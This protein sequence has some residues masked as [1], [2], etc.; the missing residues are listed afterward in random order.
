[1]APLTKVLFL[2]MDAADRDLVQQWAAEG[3]MPNVQ[4]L[5][6]RGVVG[7]TLAPAGFFVGS[8]WP[9][10]TTG[11]SP[12]RHSVHSWEQIRNGT[13]EV[14]RCEAPVELKREPFWKVLSRAGKRL[15]ILDMPLSGVAENLNGIQIEEWGH[16]DAVHGF[17]TWPPSL[18]D[19]V[20]EKFGPPPGFSCDA[21]RTPEQLAAF[22]DRLVQAVRKKADLTCHYLQQGGW[23]FFSQVFTESHCVGHQCWH[24]Q[25]TTSPWYQPAIGAVAGNPLK[26]V[27]I[28]IDRAMG[29]ILSLVGDDTIVIFVIGHGM[30]HSY[31][32]YYLFPQILL[33]L[34]VAKPRTKQEDARATKAATDTTLSAVW[35]ALPQGMKDMLRPLRNNLRDWIDHDPNW[36]RPGGPRHI[37]L[38]A[39]QCFT[40]DN[41]H[42]ASAIRLNLAG[43]EPSGVL[44][45]G[46]EVEAF[47]AQL[48]RDLLEIRDIDRDIPAFIK[49][50]KTS[51]LFQGE[52]LDAL[53]DL[54]A[55]WNPA[56]PVGKVRLSS[57]K[58]G[59]LEGE[60]RLS[61]TGEHKREGLFAAVGRDLEPR[62]LNRTVTV[63]DFAPTFTALFG[64]ELENVDG[65][66]IAEVIGRVDA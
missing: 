21:T 45:P 61:R 39:S 11:V 46:P 34:G 66:P 41:N 32:A 37:D 63:M 26:D 35:R 57:P 5:I 48:E 14:F 31:G 40:V 33:R 52:Q 16:H 56:M 54:L 58:L 49:V 2:E 59:L 4:R 42:A 65:Q 1:M 47:C 28:E 51:D 15:A 44:H 60:Y 22:R 62:R 64:V 10:L 43:R 23:D 13:Y 24:L 38:A 36:E 25:D 53:P 17:K 55:Q 7:Q 6:Q 3:L 20:V 27:Y 9:S 18:A 30:A 12:A 19:E 8:M 29:R 50:E